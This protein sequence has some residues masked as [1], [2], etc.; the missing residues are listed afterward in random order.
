[1]INRE[2]CREGFQRR[3]HDRCTVVSAWYFNR[4]LVVTRTGSFA[5]FLT[6][7]SHLLAPIFNTFKVDA[8]SSTVTSVNARCG[9]DLQRH[10]ISLAYCMTTN[11]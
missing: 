8:M 2:G 6:D 11:D 1:M 9:I 3:V 7:P 5:L 10:N 4:V